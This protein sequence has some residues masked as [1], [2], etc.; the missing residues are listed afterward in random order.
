MFFFQTVSFFDIVSQTKSFFS[1]PSYFE[2]T[3]HCLLVWPSRPSRSKASEKTWWERIICTNTSG[4]VTT[5][6]DIVAQ[7]N[8]LGHCGL[9]SPRIDWVVKCQ[10]VAW[11]CSRIYGWIGSRNFRNK[12]GNSRNG[13]LCV[14]LFWMALLRATYWHWRP[15]RSGEHSGHL[16]SSTVTLVMLLVDG[17]FGSKP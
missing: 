9:H 5:P 1:I 17:S 4:R 6:W 10:P 13:F 14:F 8:A 2:Y 3:G 7:I 16:F 11:L 12:R 15:R